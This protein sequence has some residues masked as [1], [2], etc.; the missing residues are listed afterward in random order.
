MLPLHVSLDPQ[1]GLACRQ[2]SSSWHVGVC[3]LVGAGVGALEVGMTPALISRT[4]APVTTA[5]PPTLLASSLL[6]ELVRDVSCAALLCICVRLVV[7]AANSEGGTATLNS[8]FSVPSK[9][10]NSRPSN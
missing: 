5:E 10:L 1:E 6:M 4:V 3:G 8:T 9:S 7:M 2:A